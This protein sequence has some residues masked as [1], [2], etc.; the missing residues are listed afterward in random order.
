MPGT[1][2]IAVKYAGQ[3]IPKSPFAVKVDGS[4]GDP[5]KVTVRG[6]GIEKS[7]VV[8]KRKTNFDAFTRSTCSGDSLALGLV[9]II[10]WCR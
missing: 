9:V 2:Q 5:S 6:P 3:N 10:I 8:V 4:P 1:Y 7:G